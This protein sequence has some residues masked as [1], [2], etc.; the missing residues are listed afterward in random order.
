MSLVNIEPTFI[1]VRREHEKLN[2][3]QIILNTIKLQH[4]SG[5]ESNKLM[6]EMEILFNIPGLN[7]ENFNLNNPKVMKLY[8]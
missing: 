5:I 6:N 1:C 4:K 2:H 8:M 7:D 3:Q